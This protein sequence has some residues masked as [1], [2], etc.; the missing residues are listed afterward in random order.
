MKNIDLTGGNL[1]DAPNDN[2]KKFFIKFQE[3][4]NIEVKDWKVVHILSYF[5]KK[6][7]EAYNID[8]KFKFN[9]PAPSK[10]FEV[11][12]IK[13]L[14]QILSSNP[15]ILKEY[16]DWVYLN[17]VVKAKRR[18]TSIS[19]LTTEG[20]VNEYKIKYLLSP[21]QNISRETLL[22][23]NLKA[24]FNNKG[25]SVNTYGDVAFLSKMDDFNII[26]VL[27]EAEL[28]GLNQQ[29]LSRIV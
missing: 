3:I 28:I 11:F 14:S 24:L 19:F 20:V 21:S 6:Y 4:E 17:K 2:Y 22:P 7:K 16:I 10:C 26:G 15:S 1:G 29:I 23:E 9:N 18:L 5:C 13:K 8:Y 25:F 12:Q 27:Q